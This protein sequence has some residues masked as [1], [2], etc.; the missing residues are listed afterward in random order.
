MTSTGFHNRMMILLTDY[1]VELEFVGCF[2]KSLFGSGIYRMNTKTLLD[3][4]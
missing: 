4:Q 1:V 2:K 3:L